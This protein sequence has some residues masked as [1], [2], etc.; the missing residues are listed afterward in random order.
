V[1]KAEEVGVRVRL[2]HTSRGKAARAEPIAL[3]FE[4]KRAFFAGS[5]PW[6]EDELAALT[7]G[8][9]EPIAGSRGRDGLGD[10]G[11]E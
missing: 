3:W 9:P 5:S 10:D 6:L 7:A 4:S 11:I 8:K 1:L 2:V